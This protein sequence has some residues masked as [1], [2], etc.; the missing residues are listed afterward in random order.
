MTGKTKVLI[1]GERWCDAKPGGS[2]SNL[3]HNI[4]G[5]LESTDLAEITTVFIDEIAAGGG[6]VDQAVVAAVSENT[7]DILYFTPL[8]GQQIN[9]AAATLDLIHMKFD[10]PIVA[11]YWNTALPGQVKFADTF[12][13]AVDFN[14]AID[15]YSVYPEISTRPE[16][17]LPLWTPQDPRI[18]NRDD[19]VRD[20]DVSFIGSTA[21]YADR[22]AALTRLVKAGIPVKK[23]GSQREQ[24]LS[25]EDYAALL[26]RS[27]VTLNFSK[28]F[29]PEVPVHQFKGRV[30]EAMLCGALLLEPNN[31][32]T[33]RWFTP[34]EEFDTFSSF[35]ELIEKISYYI[36]HKDA[37]IAMT[38]K[39]AAKASVMLSAQAFWTTVFTRANLPGYNQEITNVSAP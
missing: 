18:F 8:P 32:Q 38:E 6:S 10:V 26:R 15:C 19:T 2:P 35:D 36:S 17:F 39:A 33:R 7:P 24:R 37:R 20:I 30:L 29:A 21:R 3:H 4:I 28:V 1:V 12:G 25:I 9:P 22:E 27:R 34:G 5:S 11:M 16:S 31:I 23:S 14:I 13:D